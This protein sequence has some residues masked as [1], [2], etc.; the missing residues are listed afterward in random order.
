MSQSRGLRALRP[1]QD[2]PAGVSAPATPT[3]RLLALAHHNESFFKAGEMKGCADAARQRHGEVAHDV[4]RQP[5]G[6]CAGDPGGSLLS[7]VPLAEHRLRPVCRLLALGRAANRA[8]P[9]SGLGLL[10][11]EVVRV[12]PFDLVDLL[13]RH[14]HAVLDHEA[15]QLRA[16]H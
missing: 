2:Y 12:D 8:G 14:A 5:A 16:V 7:R 9:P 10:L 3:T 15:G 6:A 13:G 4:P 11:Q 1:L